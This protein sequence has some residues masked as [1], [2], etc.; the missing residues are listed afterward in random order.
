MLVPRVLLAAGLV[1]AALP[2]AAPPASAYC[3]GTLCAPYCPVCVIVLYEVGSLH[4]TEWTTLST[5]TVTCGT[6]LTGDKTVSQD[7]PL[8]SNGPLC[9]TETGK[10]SVATCTLP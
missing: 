5:T 6:A 2:L 1:L 7:A 10:G 9:F 3:V 4:C 8:P